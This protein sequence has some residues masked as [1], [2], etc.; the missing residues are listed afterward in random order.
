M[1][2]NYS[3]SFVLPN[4]Q[5]RNEFQGTGIVYMHD[6]LKQSQCGIFILLSCFKSNVA[7]LV[8]YCKTSFDLKKQ[9]LNSLSQVCEL[10][11]LCWVVFLW[12]LSC[13]CSQVRAGAVVMCSLLGCAG[14]LIHSPLWQL[15]LA[16]H[17]ELNWGL[18]VAPIQGIFMWLGLLMQ[19]GL[20]KSRFFHGGWLPSGNIPTWSVLRDIGGSWEAGRFLV[21]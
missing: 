8:A 16:F 17:W 15:M 19:S 18:T 5:V 9:F 21:T 6:N 1:A 11:G 13:S 3:L 14:W 10:T 2:Q 7:I 12:S 20:A 4:I